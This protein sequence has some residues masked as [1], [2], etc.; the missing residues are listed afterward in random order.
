MPWF[1]WKTEHESWY[2][3]LCGSWATNEHIRGPRHQSRAANR[4]WHGFPAEDEPHD[5]RW[6][7]PWFLA[8]EGDWPLCLL[9][10]TGASPEHLE[11]GK[12]K[13]RAA[14]PDTYCPGCGYEPIPAAA[15]APAPSA[16][17]VPE[18]AGAD[19]APW[20]VPSSAPA[21]GDAESYVPP[22]GAGDVPPSG[23]LQIGSSS[24]TDANGQA[25]GL[26]RWT[27]MAKGQAPPPTTADAEEWEESQADA[28]AFNILPTELVNGLLAGQPGVGPSS[29]DGS[30]CDGQP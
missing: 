15:P 21:R 27:K 22:S 16:A 3:N 10:N 26:R 11:T 28:Q 1:E 18:N 30:A 4:A 7:A 23:F 2:C 25:A 29:I 5:P 19:A 8:R 6:D 20:P 13:K 24:G 17:P 9:C 12:H 14:Y